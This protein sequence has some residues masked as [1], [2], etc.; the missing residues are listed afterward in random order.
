M[1]TIVYV[2]GL[3]VKVMDVDAAQYASI[4]R[5]MLSNHQYLQVLYNRENYLD[6][7]PLLFWLSVLSFKIFGVSTLAYKFPSFLFTLMGV[8]ATYR[9][10]K[11]FYNE[12]TA[13]LATLFLYT[14]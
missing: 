9:L 6:K 8:Y 4:S 2:V 14:C 13:L 11:R 3:L 12:Q 7:P 5:E 10:T 1:A